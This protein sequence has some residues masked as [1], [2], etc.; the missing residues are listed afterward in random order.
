MRAVTLGPP[1]AERLRSGSGCRGVYW[2][3]LSSE[4]ETLTGWAANTCR[5]HHPCFWPTGLSMSFW[6][7]LD[8]LVAARF[9]RLQVGCYAGLSKADSDP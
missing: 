2:G 9:V 7:K 3:P 5:F 4:D 8:G 6:G 1:A